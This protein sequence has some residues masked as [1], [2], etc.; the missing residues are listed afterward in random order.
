MN[1]G[2]VGSPPRDVLRAEKD[3][4]DRV[5]RQ[6]ASNYHGTF[7]DVRTAI[8]PGF[9]T[10]SATSPRCVGVSART[11]MMVVLPMKMVSPLSARNS[12]NWP[13]RYNSEPMVPDGP[14]PTTPEAFAPV[15]ESYFQA[16][17][18][19]V[20]TI[21]ASMIVGAILMAAISRA[22]LSPRSGGFGNI[23]LG[24]DELRVF[25]VTLVIALALQKTIGLRRGK[26]Q[27]VAGID[28]A[29]H[30]EVAY[31]L[32]GKTHTP[33][34]HTTP[35]AVIASAERLVAGSA[36]TESTAG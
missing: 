23:R 24:M 28:L 13:A 19:M 31:D 27:E 29:E 14:A 12:R 22:V 1:V 5:A 26:E 32:E 20:W 7:L 18:H 2:T 10:F 11:I 25:V 6:A 35:E 8:A 16:M 4:L 34:T 17:G 15:I 30:A 3:E 21:P 33:G 9:G 36:H